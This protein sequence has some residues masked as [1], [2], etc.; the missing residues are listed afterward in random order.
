[1]LSLLIIIIDH[2][3]KTINPLLKKLDIIQNSIILYLLRICPIRLK[4]E[5]GTSSLFLSKTYYTI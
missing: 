5:S 4:T 2:H 3:I 1:M